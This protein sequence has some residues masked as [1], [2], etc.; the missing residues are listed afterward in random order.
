[1]RTEL[2]VAFAGSACLVYVASLVPAHAHSESC[3]VSGI[4]LPAPDYRPLLPYY[5]YSGPLDPGGR[6]DTHPAP[7][8]WRSLP[9]F[10]AEERGW[11]RLERMMTGSRSLRA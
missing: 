3:E 11:R 1:M 10:P 2:R 7:R 6:I 9:L 8:R 5:V 4:S